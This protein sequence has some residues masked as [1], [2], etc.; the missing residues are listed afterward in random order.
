MPL[1]C[2]VAEALNA[3][4]VTCTTVPCAPVGGLMPAIQSPPGVPEL[5]AL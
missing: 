3:P 5:V 2:A 1:K 4:P